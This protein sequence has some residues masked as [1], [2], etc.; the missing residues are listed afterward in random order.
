[1]PTRTHRTSVVLA[2]LLAGAIAAPMLGGCTPSSD[3]PVES[4]SDIIAPV[5]SSTSPTDGEVAGSA[6]ADSAASDAIAFDYSQGITSEGMWEGVTAASIV[7]LPADYAS[8]EVPADVAAISDAEV[9]SHMETIASHY[10]VET[11]QVTDRAVEMGDTINIDYVGKI[12][13]VAFDGGSTYSTDADGNQV[14]NG[15]DVTVGVTN[16]IDDFLEQLV[17]HKPGE[18]FDI[19]VTF[20]E[21]YG[22]EELNGKDAVFTVTI[23]YITQSKITDEWVAQNMQATY[24]CS[25]VDEFEDVLRAEMQ[26]GQIEAY[27]QDYAISNAQVK[28]IPSSMVEYQRGALL[29]YYQGM[30]DSYGMDL[31]EMISMVTSGGTLEEL[32]DS[33]KDAIEL[34]VSSYLVYQAIAEEQGIAVDEAEARAFAASNF[35]EA[36]V[37]AYIDHYGANYI[38]LGALID[39]VTDYLA[40]N[41]NVAE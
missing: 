33:N 26:R 41:A 25:T 40:D 20:P 34:T 38:R 32:L 11:E 2:A 6:A 15:T 10:G 1:M 21:N 13:G 9:R 17:G 29:S 12:D 4:S 27:V 8:I 35:G 23:N 7:T 16:Y 14:A 37:D 31:D 39:K 3:Q 22:K 24:G 30:A 36:N 19:E 18:T 5:N 28:E